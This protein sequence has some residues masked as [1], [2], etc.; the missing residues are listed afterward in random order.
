MDFPISSALQRWRL[1]FSPSQMSPQ[2][3]EIRGHSITDCR[4]ILDRLL[5]TERNWGRII[6]IGF[7]R[8]QLVFFLWGGGLVERIVVSQKL[9][10]LC[11]C[12]RSCFTFLEKFHEAWFHLLEKLGAWLPNVWAPRFL[13]NDRET[14]T[15]LP[16][17]WDPNLA[18]N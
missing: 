3:N 12:P 18:D 17:L 11:Y 10:P 8:I 15:N 16:D 13:K 14:T 6:H 9:F 5:N 1:Q 7:N 4:R 2:A